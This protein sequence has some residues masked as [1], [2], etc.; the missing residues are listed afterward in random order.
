MQ[1]VLKGDS[2]RFDWNRIGWKAER[3]IGTLI[4]NV[5]RWARHPVAKALR[6]CRFVPNLV[7]ETARK[8]AD[9]LTS[10]WKALD[11][12][13][14]Q[15]AVK[16]DTQVACPHC[17]KLG[18]LTDAEYQPL[19][20]FRPPEPRGLAAP[21]PSAIAGETALPVWL[22]IAYETR[23]AGG[24][25]GVACAVAIL[26]V[27]SPI[28]PPPRGAQSE[29]FLAAVDDGPLARARRWAAALPVE[30]LSEIVLEAARDATAL[31]GDLEELEGAAL[32]DSDDA[33]SVATALALDWLHRRDD[34]ACLSD[35]L[36]Q[37]SIGDPLNMA[38]AQ[39][40]RVAAE[41]GSLWSL[42]AGLPGDARLRAAAWTRPDAY[43]A[44]FALG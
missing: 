1:S 17:G 32:S 8:W 43:W 40:D 10:P 11:Q 25:L 39:L 26:G 2:M 28:V 13:F 14:L 37:P 7:Q 12:F 31:Q 27:Y 5:P 42:V 20:A 24:P 3:H 35:V 41:A 30:T 15:V 44:V 33:E 22:Q 9:D 19:H 6:A 34:L 18:P 16:I 23:L 21:D 4:P 36:P 29:A 38:L